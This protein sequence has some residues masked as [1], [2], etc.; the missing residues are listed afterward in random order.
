[1]CKVYRSILQFLKEI[2]YFD[3]FLDLNGLD[4]NAEENRT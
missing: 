2:Y 1:W 3:N 4:K